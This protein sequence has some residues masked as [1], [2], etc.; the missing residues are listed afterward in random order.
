[1]S[2][3]R[4]GH[5]IESEAGICRGKKGRLRENVSYLEMCPVDRLAESFSATPSFHLLKEMDN[6]P[7]IEFMYLVFTCMPGESY[8]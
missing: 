4:A 2:Q 8:L 6:V 7:L 5:E 3:V 1:M